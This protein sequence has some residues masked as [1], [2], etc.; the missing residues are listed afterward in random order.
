MRTGA[1]GAR[2]KDVG[3]RVAARRSVVTARVLERTERRGP[4]GS[5]EY[6]CMSAVY[7]GHGR[8]PTSE[9][10]QWA[11]PTHERVAAGP[12]AVRRIAHIIPQT[13]TNETR[14]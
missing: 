5:E 2:A 13:P 6:G 3:T 14:G 10:D 11:G 7:R 12:G 8:R 9:S 4:V 1:R